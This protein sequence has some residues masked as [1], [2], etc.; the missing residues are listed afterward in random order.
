LRQ[1]D[2]R[3]PRLVAED[4]GRHIYVQ[5]MGTRAANDAERA[6]FRREFEEKWRAMAFHGFND[7][8]IW[9]REATQP[10][11]EDD[12]GWTEEHLYESDVAIVEWRKFAS[13][14]NRGVQTPADTIR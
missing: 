2:S 11:Y 3:R 13:T 14:H 9:A 10:F 1:R 6:A 4:A 8:D 12:L 7:D 5:T